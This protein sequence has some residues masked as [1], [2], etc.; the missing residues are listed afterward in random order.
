MNVL[1]ILI[2]AALAIGLMRGLSTGAVRQI[3]SIIGV[4]I[5]FILGV[6]LMQPVGALVVESLGLAEGLGPLIGFVLVF[7]AIQLAVLALAVGL[8]TVIG[9]LQLSFVNRLLGGVAG[10]AKAALLLS[11]AFLVL[12]YFGLPDDETRQTSELYAPVASVLP[13]AWDYVSEQLPEVERLSERFG[14]E[15]RERLPAAD[16]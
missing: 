14:R 11:V 13:G 16:E 7:A 8:E 12:A 6:Q 9:A 10:A 1:D 5:A 2:L 4:V 3:T 15:V